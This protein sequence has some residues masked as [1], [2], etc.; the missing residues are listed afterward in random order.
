VADGDQ[1]LDADILRPALLTHRIKIQEAVSVGSVLD[2]LCL[3][4]D[5][6]NALGGIPKGCT[7]ALA[8]PPGA[9]IPSECAEL[10][11][12]AGPSPPPEVR[13]VALDAAAMSDGVSATLSPAESTEDVP[14]S[15]ISARAT[16][17]AAPND[18]AAETVSEEKKTVRP[19]V[20]STRRIAARPGP[21]LAISS[22]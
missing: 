14:V 7:I 10:E 20:A 17:P 22:R 5:G 9:S 1:G 2:L 15:S 18:R 6:K 16:R 3:T 4:E 21:S 19:E 8:G 12:R 13:D 11:P